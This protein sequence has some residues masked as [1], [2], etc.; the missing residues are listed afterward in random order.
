MDRV[1]QQPPSVRADLFRE[2]ASRIGLPP[3][4]VEKDFWVCWTLKQIFSIDD[5][6]GKV[7]FKGGTSLSKIFNVIRRFS[8]DIDL[9]IDFEMLGFTGERH[10]ANA[11]SRN[12]RQKILDEM[13][14]ACRA[15]V[16]GDFIALLNERFAP[17]LAG[18]SAWQLR[19]RASDPSSVVVEFEYPASLRVSEAVSYVRPMVVL[20]PGTH[21]EFIPRGSYQI[22]PFAAE[23]FPGVFESASC[24]VEAITAERTFWEKATILHA[25]YYRPADKPLVSRH[26]RHYYDIAMLAGCP[27]KMAALADHE[28]LKRV[29]RHK[30][31]F[32]YSRWAR[33][34]LAVPG[35]LR[36]VPAEARLAGLHRDYLA[37]RDMIFDE[38]PSW[39]EIL[40]TLAGLEQE[41]NSL[42][43]A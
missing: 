16:E 18:P 14:I 22:R 28:L 24:T 37:M 26:S 35:T 7:L 20:E 2:T 23:Q 32:Y 21:A 11:P 40:K 13:L 39:D 38:P 9:A 1:A 4:L 27:I 29:V 33:Y 19:T 15:Y 41:I 8:E 10:P 34:D 36:L 5:L 43:L 25:E 3:A 12:S 30:S 31:E 42:K 17:I 6:K